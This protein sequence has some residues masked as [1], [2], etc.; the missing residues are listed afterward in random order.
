MCNTTC[1]KNQYHGQGRALSRQAYANAACTGAPDV[2][3]AWSYDP[4]DTI[5]IGALKQSTVVTTNG[6]SSH[7]NVFAY[8]AERQRVARLDY[9]TG[10]TNGSPVTTTHYV[11]SAEIVLSPLSAVAPILK[12]YLPGLILSM[13]GG[14]ISYEYLFTDALAKGQISILLV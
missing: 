10:S 14:P 12:R 11:G 9:A 4:V 2:N 3:V 8:G 13:N 1:S 5:G 7:G 6:Y